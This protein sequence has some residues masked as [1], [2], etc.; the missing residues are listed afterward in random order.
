MEIQG[1]FSREKNHKSRPKKC[2]EIQKS[3]PKKCISF[4][5]SRP[6]KCV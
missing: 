6:K 4:V 2:V 3:R 1:Y 5:K